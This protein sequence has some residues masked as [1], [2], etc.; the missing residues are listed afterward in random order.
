M[1]PKFLIAAALSLGLGTGI[2]MAQNDML[3]PDA[4]PGSDAETTLPMGWEGPIGDAFFADPATGTLR[5]ED[6]VR[7]NWQGLT[8]EQQAEVRTYCATVDT[9]AATPPDQ[10]TDDQMTTGS[11]TPDEANQVAAIQQACGWVD[12]M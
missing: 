8:E 7:A 3:Q 11:I 10:M 6:E 9:A 1:T 4:A 12:A 2:A 5:T